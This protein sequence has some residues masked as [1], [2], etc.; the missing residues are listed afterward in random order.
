MSRVGNDVFRLPSGKLV[1]VSTV[2]RTY[3]GGVEYCRGR[4]MVIASIHSQADA[5]S[6]E[7]LLP[8]PTYLGAKERHGTGQAKHLHMGKFEWEDGS[9]FDFVNERSE[10]ANQYYCDEGNG[11]SGLGLCAGELFHHQMHDETHIAAIPG[12]LNPAYMQVIHG[13]NDTQWATVNNIHQWVDYGI[14]DSKL[15]VVCSMRNAWNGGPSP[16]STVSK[17]CPGLA[18]QGHSPDG[19][20]CYS[21]PTTGVATNNQCELEPAE[22]ASLRSMLQEFRGGCAWERSNRTIG[23]LLLGTDIG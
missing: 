19:E 4:G 18:G 7:F 10:M 8:G 20:S 13:H 2:P 15:A 23:S 5:D 22:Q 11:R 14:G 16:L 21:P 17:L 6:L 3:L 1:A 9:D 12:K